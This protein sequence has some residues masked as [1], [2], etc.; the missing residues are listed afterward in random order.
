MSRYAPKLMELAPRD[1]VSRAIYLEVKA[2]LGAGP[3]GDY[4]LLDVRHLGR[5]VIEEK[6]PDITDF[7]A[8]QGRAATELVRLQP[9]AH[10]AMGGIR[11]TSGPASPATS[12][13]RWCP[14]CTP[15]ARRHA[16]ASTERTASGRTRSSTCSHAL[17]A[18]RPLPRPLCRR[19]ATRTR[20]SARSR[21][22]AVP[23][24]GEPVGLAELVR[25]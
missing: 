22:R 7:A 8:H 3:L 14:G 24:R 21:R 1:M 6:L 17:A 10:Y 23:R 18:I 25:L 15:P 2:G 5:K 13:T 11:P 4:V 20:L 9:T 12:T 16:S 19:C